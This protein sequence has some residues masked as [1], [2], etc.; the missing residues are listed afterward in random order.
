VSKK[1]KC[2]YVQVDHK[3]Y[4]CLQYQSDAHLMHMT[5]QRRALFTEDFRL[6]W[7]LNLFKGLTTDPCLQNCRKINLHA[8]TCYVPIHDSFCGLFAYTSLS[9]CCWQ[10]N[11]SM[12]WESS[13]RQNTV[14]FMGFLSHWMLSSTT[15]LVEI[16]LLKVYYEY[17]L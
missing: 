1:C 4:A 16:Y 12:L 5:S 11:Y 3:F 15:I 14:A 10:C 9:Q 7:S 17:S 8:T 2:I 6:H 13:K